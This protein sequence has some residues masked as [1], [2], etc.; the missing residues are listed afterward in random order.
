[1]GELIKSEAKE[2]S[3]KKLAVAFV[4]LNVLDCALTAYFVGNGTGTELNP[5]MREALQTPALFWL[6]KV[7]GSTVL[8]LALIGLDKLLA[9]HKLLTKWFLVRRVFELLVILMVGICVFN[10]VGIILVR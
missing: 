9:E 1:M 8:S 3:V 5:L 6:I 2:V 4:G 7:G 10:I